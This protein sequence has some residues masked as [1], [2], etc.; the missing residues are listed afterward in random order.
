MLLYRIPESQFPDFQLETPVTLLLEGP[1]SFASWLAQPLDP[2]I[3]CFETDALPENGEALPDPIIQ[4]NG[5]VPG[6]DYRILDPETDF[7]TLYQLA[8]LAPNFPVRARIA[9]RP[10]AAKALKLAQALNI[11]TL[12]LLEQPDGDTIRLLADLLQ[13]FL[14][15][16]EYEVAV[17]PFS[18]LLAAHIHQ[19]PLNLWDLPEQ[20]PVTTV[21]MNREGHLHP[22]GRVAHLREEPLESFRKSFPDRAADHPEC[23]ACPH[24]DRCQ[25]FFK[26]PDPSYDCTLLR[27]QLLD[28]IAQAAQDLQVILQE[29]DP[30]SSP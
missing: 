22:P 23:R 24:R 3:V 27:Q 30:P 1:G 20:N 10:G 28:P 5:A 11:E 14:H 8:Q 21:E 2:R 15:S 17:E 26:W 19:Q 4:E 9:T 29:S 13:R 7:P 18:S 16:D 25:G 6:I 12:L